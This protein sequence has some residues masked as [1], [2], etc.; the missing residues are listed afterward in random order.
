MRVAALALLAAAS[1]ALPAPARAAE[2]IGVLCSFQPITQPLGDGTAKTGVLVAGPSAGD[3]AITCTVQLTPTR[4]TGVVGTVSAAGDPVLANAT[5]VSYD[6]ARRDDPVWLCAAFTPTGGTTLYYDDDR[7]DFTA[8]PAA[9]CGQVPQPCE[10][11]PSDPLRVLDP[12]VCPVLALVFPPS[13]DVPL[14]WD[15]PPYDA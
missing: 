15:C 10:C 2:P 13:G 4:G 6:V 7:G 9:P 11:G 12:L 3:G 8:G 5:V 14:V 1:V